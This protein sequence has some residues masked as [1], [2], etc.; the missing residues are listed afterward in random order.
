MEFL[1]DEGF[2]SSSSSK[3]IQKFEYPMTKDRINYNVYIIYIIKSFPWLVCALAS[4][5][6]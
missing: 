6:F 5:W 3:I 4:S 2:N 1:R